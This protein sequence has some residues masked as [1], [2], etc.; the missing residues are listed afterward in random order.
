MNTG[1]L[2]I[3]TP[4]DREIAMTRVFNAPRRLVF[5]A[6]TKPELIK[7]WLSGLDGWTMAVCE[8]DLR[9]GGAYRYV[10]RRDDDGTEMGMGGIIREIVV[11]ERLVSTEKFDEAWYSGEA[12]GTFVLV[13]QDGKTTLTQTMRYESRET[14]DAVLQSPME[15]GVMA[16]YDRFAELLTTLE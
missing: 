4:T 15:D 1:T 13:E 11:P 14:R 10:W 3:T 16:S 12:L 2:Q 7:R 8:F 9:V 6:L 5:D